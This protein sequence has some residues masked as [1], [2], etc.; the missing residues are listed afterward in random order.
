MKQVAGI[1]LPDGEADM[2]QYLMAS[3]GVYQ[4]TQLNRSLEFVTS[5]DLAIDV[6]AHVGLWSKI[7]V[8]KFRRVV[9]FEP[10]APMRACLEK[11]VTSD[12]LQTVPI[13]LGNRHGAVAFN[14]DESHTGST[15]V[16][17]KKPGIIPLGKLDDFRLQNVGYIKLDCEGFEQDALEGAKETLAQSMPIVIVEEKLHGQRHYGKK[18]YAAIEFLESLGA[19]LLD[20]I[21]DDLILGWPSVPGKVAPAKQ[22]P[23]E[24]HL[25]MAQAFHEKGDLV[26][27][28]IL[29][30]KLHKDHPRVPEVANLL[31]LAELQLGDHDSAM[32]HA[33]RACQLNMKEARYKNTLGTCL[34]MIGREAEAVAAIEAALRDNPNLTEAHENLAQM[35]TQRVR[36]EATAASYAEALAIHPNSPQLLVKLAA[37]HAVHGSA[38]QARTLY[39]RALAID[40][41]NCDAKTGLANLAGREAA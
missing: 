40:P 38:D 22:T 32:E 31:S 36:L 13:A 41:T 35:R 4:I 15:H 11:N 10:M 27:A 30:C 20:R 28:R 18:P 19:E 7:L 16:D 3:G 24:H 21:G 29:Y 8:Q 12:R 33:A 14:Y 37:I 9:A 23:P 17:L 39:D 2:P 1:Y 6:G 26:G 5:W 25:A 34:W